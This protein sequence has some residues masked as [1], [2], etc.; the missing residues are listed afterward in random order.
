MAESQD[1]LKTGDYN[2]IHGRIKDYYTVEKQNQQVTK[3]AKE[4]TADMIL[5]NASASEVITAM[6]QPIGYDD[7]LYYCHTKDKSKSISRRYRML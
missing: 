5:A 2:I 1:H 6:E 4:N 3:D 7:K